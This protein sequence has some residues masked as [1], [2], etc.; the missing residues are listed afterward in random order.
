MN[1]ARD[2]LGY[3]CFSLSI[4][5]CA[6]GGCK[7]MNNPNE[8][9]RQKKALCDEWRSANLVPPHSLGVIMR[10]TQ[11]AAGVLA[12]NTGCTYSWEE[13]PVICSLSF[14]N[15]RDYRWRLNPTSA[16]L[17][18]L[19]LECCDFGTAFEFAYNSGLKTFYSWKNK[20][21]NQA[22]I[23]QNTLKHRRV[24]CRK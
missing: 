16:S 7:C 8:R 23:T 1:S 22:S 2:V 20:I 12:R 9:R 21:N 13:Q 19:V 10:S 11:P 6:M 5:Q 4:E 3:A 24:T 15:V 18:W 14:D 17:K